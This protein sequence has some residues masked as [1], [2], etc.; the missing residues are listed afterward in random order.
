MSEFC[1]SIV[2]FSGDDGLPIEFNIQN[3]VEKVPLKNM[4]E[5]GGGLCTHSADAIYVVSR[6][7]SVINVDTDKKI[8][9]SR[10][11]FECVKQN[12]LL[13]MDDYKI[14][15]NEVEA[16]D[17]SE[18][19]S[20]QM[21]EKDGRK[22]SDND[23]SVDIIDSN[24]NISPP[25]LLLSS[26]NHAFDFED[27]ENRKI[28][29]PRKRIDPTPS[30]IIPFQMSS[31]C[32]ESKL[33]IST[34]PEGLDVSENERSKPDEGVQIF[35]DSLEDLDEPIAD[36]QNL[37][38]AEE[39]EI[40]VNG[41]DVC[42]NHS[43]DVNKGDRDSPFNA[44]IVSSSQPNMDGLDQFD[45]MV[46]NKL[47]ERPVPQD[48]ECLSQSYT[49]SSSADAQIPPSKPSPRDTSAEI[50]GG[51]AAIPDSASQTTERQQYINNLEKEI[52]Q[53]LQKPSPKSIQDKIAFVKYICC[54]K[55][56]APAIVLQTLQNF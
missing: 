48:D 27:T 9:S 25:L 24:K 51:S 23:N 49:V 2:L 35:H 36:G 33:Q 40:Q 53:I 46:L 45:N 42:D 41:E 34:T 26:S 44:I 29:E 37:D 28:V 16:S 13:D 12:Y 20:F 19:N 5:Y 30:P 32:N 54:V 15:I 1:H 39:V 4:I 18:E 3:A 6:G 47:Q 56:L 52:E 10:Y 43:S 21:M 17:F 31:N 38:V 8:I 7:T 55:K 11:I 22:S 14:E 50:F